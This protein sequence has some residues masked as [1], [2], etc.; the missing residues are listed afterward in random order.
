MSK[1]VKDKND[2]DATHWK[3]ALSEAEEEL[4][5]ARQRVKTLEMTVRVFRENLENGFP[6][7]VNR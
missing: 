5:R 2:G 3:Q 7:P 4:N 1:K 6:F